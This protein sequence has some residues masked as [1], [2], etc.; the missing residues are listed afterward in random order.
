MKKI[1]G[2]LIFL[3][4][5]NS[6][7]GTTDCS[8]PMIKDRNVV[9]LLPTHF[10]PVSVSAF[11]TNN[12]ETN[13][14]VRINGIRAEQRQFFFFSATRTVLSIPVPF[15]VG[16]NSAKFVRVGK[17]T[18]EIRGQL[19]VGDTLFLEISTVGLLPFAIQ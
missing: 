4:S 12:C 16:L 10:T 14:I 17:E 7:A 19:H 15:P 6:F 2:I 11:S 1:I 8:A 5:V 3:G 18:I 13:L 9:A